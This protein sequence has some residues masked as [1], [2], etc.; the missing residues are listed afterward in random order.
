MATTNSRSEVMPVLH[1]P[2]SNSAPEPLESPQHDERSQAGV[3]SNNLGG[4]APSVSGKRK[5]E[6]FP[7][8]VIS[9]LMTWARAHASAPYPNNRDLAMLQSRTSLTIKQLNYWFSNY[10]RRQR[11]VPPT[12]A[13]A[14]AAAPQ[15]AAASPPQQA[16]SPNFSAPSPVSAGQLAAELLRPVPPPSGVVTVA[17]AA[18]VLPPLRLPAS[19]VPAMSGIFAGAS[20]AAPPRLPPFSSLPPSPASLTPLPFVRAS[21]LRHSIACPATAVPM[22]SPLA[23]PSFDLLLSGKAPSMS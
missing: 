4:N 12:P 14:P 19:G 20:A 3:Q 21:L 5:R 13:A 18:P 9:E 11:H 2:E 23:L 17:Q 10:R 16:A 22:A 8:E 1:V 6:N 7:Q 15:P